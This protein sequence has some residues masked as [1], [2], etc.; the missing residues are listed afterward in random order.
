MKTLEL[1]QD[2]LYH[3]AKDKKDRKFYSLHDKL[4][5]LD[6]FQDAWKRVSANGGSPGI[7]RKSIEDIESYGVPRFLNEIQHEL[8]KKEY[9]VPRVRRVYI[10]K[11]DGK[12]RPLGIPT[13]KDRVVQQAVKSIIEP[14]FEADF[15]DFSYA[16]RKG[17]SAKQASTEIYRYINYGYTKVVEIDIKGFFDHIDHE[18]M[19]FFVMK[20]IADPYVI[21]LIR[22]WLRAGIVYEGETVYPSEGTPQG[23]VISPLLANIYL[24][25][26][27]TLWSKKVDVQSARMIRYADDIT[28]LAKNKP[29]KYMDLTK[30]ILDLL[31]LE[32][33][34]DKSRITDV[35]EGFDFLG[36][37]Y[38]RRYSSL[39]KKEIIKM[40]PSRR[41]MEKFREKVKEIA[42]LT[43]T[44]AKTMD[45][46]ISE[47]N[48]LI[49]GYTNYFNHTNATLQYKSLYHFVEWKVSKF[50][51]DLHKIPRVSDRNLY[52]GIGRLSG[53]MQMTGRISYIHNAAR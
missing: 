2:G 41:S 51:C 34:M 36:I 7:D 23:G 37:H 42:K 24:N 22:E 10:P 48:A 4:C 14:I 35:A 50:Y 17:R 25:E 49:R 18:K 12:Q 44:H 9:I 38:Q 29:E 30:R 28:I 39:Q 6:I 46:L 21:K 16:Y 53:L 11:Q 5:R 15:K 32:L 20:R 52:I 19:I 40:Y 31:K 1:L 3:A 47:L 13:V 45:S 43:K 8:M 27:D 33:N 26:M